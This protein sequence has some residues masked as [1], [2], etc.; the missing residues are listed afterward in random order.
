MKT[1]GDR[2]QKILLYMHPFFFAMQKAV[3]SA[4]LLHHGPIVRATFGR[5]SNAYY[6]HFFSNSWQGICQRL[7]EIRAHSL[8]LIP[9]SCL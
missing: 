9:Y 2:H 3:P 4:H 7:H 5:T 6:L 8:I 1:T